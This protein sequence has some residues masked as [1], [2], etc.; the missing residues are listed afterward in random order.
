LL[1][2]LG[3]LAYDSTTEKVRIPN[4]EVRQEFQRSVREVPHEETQRRLQESERLFSDTIAGN[5]DA[6][7]EQIEKVHAEETSPLHYNSEASLRSVI[8]LAYYAYSD[9]YL[10]WEEL[11]AGIGFADIAYL[12][13]LQPLPIIQY[14]TGAY[15]LY[16]FAHKM[17]R[18]H[19]SYDCD[20]TF[21]S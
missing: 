8:K 17:V 14:Q 13:K 20:A 1:V 5:E 2:H 6:V 12:T 3:Y 19:N 18:A 9:H 15:A 7:A 10:Q 11:P 21:Y 4:E 16:H